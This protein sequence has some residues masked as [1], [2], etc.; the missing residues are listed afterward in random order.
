[1]EGSGPMDVSGKSAEDHQ[2]AQ[3]GVITAWRVSRE[4]A[5]PGYC[6]TNV[7]NSSRGDTVGLGQ[8]SNYGENRTG[9]FC[10]ILVR[11]SS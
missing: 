9:E 4:K 1:M 11:L 2:G 5:S 3:D 10:V 6:G 8:R 7:F